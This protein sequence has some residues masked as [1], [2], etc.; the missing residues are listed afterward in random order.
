MTHAGRIRAVI[1]TTQR[2]GSTSLVVSLGTH[3]DIECAGEIL[4]GAPDTPVPQV[5][6]HFKNVVRI[7][8]I[9]R[10]GAWMPPRRMERFYAGGK[11][12]VRAFKVM[13]NQLKYPFALRY[14]QNDRAIR[15]LHL[16]RHNLLKVHVSRLLMSKRE[17]VQA[18]GPVAA[19]RTHVDPGQAIASMRKARER[20]QHFDSLFSTHPRLQLAYE[21]L[22]EG[23][24]L[25][26]A[27][28]A[29][30]CDFLEVPRHPM[31]SKLT[32]LNPESLQD[33]VTNY[34]ELANAVART[35][36]AE[37]LQ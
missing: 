11:A 1:L 21:S 2:T 31:R 29:A 35:E 33:M 12:R 10:F 36:F 22:F 27:A 14:L 17:R 30:I 7:G 18:T 23:Q 4:I 26:E 3:P 9:I 6:G 24:G 16:S 28:N 5:R 32:K 19:V 37:F 8:N 20:H 34:D 15:V 25:S 13:Y